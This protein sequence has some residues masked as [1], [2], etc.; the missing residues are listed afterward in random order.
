MPRSK[1]AHKQILR[2]ISSTNERK[3][4]PPALLDEN[5]WQAHDSLKQ[6]LLDSEM[7]VLT[8]VLLS[9]F[10]NPE[11]S[12]RK[13]KSTIYTYSVLFAVA[14]R[15]PYARLKLLVLDEP[16]IDVQLLLADARIEWMRYSAACDPHKFSED[17]HDRV[18]RIGTSVRGDRQRINFSELAMRSLLLDETLFE[19]E[20]YERQLQKPGA[21]NL[22]I[23]TPTILHEVALSRLAPAARI[24]FSLSSSEERLIRNSSVD[25]L[26][27]GR[28]GSRNRPLLAFEFDGPGH[29][30]PDQMATDQAK[31][32]ILE[33][34]GLP[35]V[36]ISS[37]EVDLRKW[38]RPN[39][40]EG[41][42]LRLFFKLVGPLAQSVASSVENSISGQLAE[43]DAML[44]MHRREE[45]LSRSMFGKDWVDLES[46]QL[47]ALNQAMQATG[48]DADYRE[49]LGFNDFLRS[50]ETDELHDLKVWPEDILQKSSAPAFVTEVDG[51]RWASTTLTIGESTLQVISP[52]I[53]I[54][55][56]PRF[57]DDPVMRE[58]IDIRIIE[59]L[60]ERVREHIE[61][62]HQPNG[63]RHA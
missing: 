45:K 61:A 27:H 44:E 63:E 24:E 34:F 26:V 23:D 62:P 6:R 16:A 30:D 5:Q 50:R 7:C 32:R 15:P 53:R 17:V 49:A 21:S 13:W 10:I 47:N 51:S 18:L 9:T 25:L 39:S 1:K 59:F 60:A 2:D 48:L 33:S 54:N 52:K 36:R 14:S 22:P 37:N 28:G 43:N 58:W 56:T 38:K 3:W 19:F 46:T 11:G 57:K 20:R 8:G 29:E 31:D 41:R 40:F 35:L 12:Q 55:L 4:W 42:K